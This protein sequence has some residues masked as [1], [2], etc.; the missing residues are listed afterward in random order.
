MCSYA[1][2]CSE[3]WTENNY[4]ARVQLFAR[5]IPKNVHEI[6]KQLCDVSENVGGKGKIAC[7]TDYRI[8]TPNEANS[9]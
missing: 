5:K 2:D 4:L 8:R 9:K 1:T 6:M 3:V 7:D